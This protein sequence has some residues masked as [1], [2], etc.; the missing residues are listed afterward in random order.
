MK[1]DNL[2]NALRKKAL[3]FV[4]DEVVEE[5]SLDA[6]GN[7]VLSKRK[8]TKKFNPPDMSA[9]K[10]LLD[11]EPDDDIGKMSD[12]QLLQEK[13]RL[14]QL[15]ADEQQKKSGAQKQTSKT[16]PK[17][18]CKETRKDT[19]QT[20]NETSKSKSAKEN[21]PKRRKIVKGGRK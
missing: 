1:D 13:Q 8:V 5:Y 2:K 4:S 3:G 7:E 15:L 14:L 11:E 19:K 10:I 21:K 9:L 12:E 17:Q 18:T 16:N 20:S 6:D